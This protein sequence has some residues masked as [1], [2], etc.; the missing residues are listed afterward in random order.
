MVAVNIFGAPP[1]PIPA[2]Q[3]IPKC[4][5]ITTRQNAAIDALHVYMA[6][7]HG[8]LGT[9]GNL[10]IATA[11]VTV[12]FDDGSSEVWFAPN[13]QISDGGILSQ[14]APISQTNPS[15]CA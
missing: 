6:T 10:L 12:A 14:A 5:S 3:P 8:V 1:T 2:T 4:S 15:V 9:A 7:P 13:A 11:N